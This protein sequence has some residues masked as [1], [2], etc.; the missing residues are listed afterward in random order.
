[1]NNDL[2]E[3]LSD[4]KPFKINDIFDS[5]ACIEDANLLG[6]FDAFL[7]QHTY[8]VH[9]YYVTKGDF[10]G[11]DVY[12]CSIG[13]YAEQYEPTPIVEGG[14]PAKR[15]WETCSAIL[16][17]ITDYPD[18]VMCISDFVCNAIEIIKKSSLI[19]TKDSIYYVP[20]YA[21]T[22]Y[23]AAVLKLDVS[24]YPISIPV[25]IQEPR[26]ANYVFLS[27]VTTK[28]L[29]ELVLMAPFTI[30]Y[31]VELRSVKPNKQPFAFSISKDVEFIN[32]K[33]HTHICYKM[34]NICL[35]PGSMDIYDNIIKTYSHYR[36]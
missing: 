1:M 7:F 12:A 26:S 5:E 27:N 17:E 29:G 21:L 32:V 35:R 15:L 13:L 11:H 4:V 34:V 30:C 22:Q 28:T 36:T 9:K 3:N 6:E 16:K 20:L 19:Q 23:T 8:T 33:P 14:F 24:A 25:L 18:N 31:D 10:A 2:V